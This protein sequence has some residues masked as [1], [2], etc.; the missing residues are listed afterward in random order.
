MGAWERFCLFLI[1]T[2]NYVFDRHASLF[3]PQSHQNLSNGV[4]LVRSVCVV[5]K[6]GC[7]R[8]IVFLTIITSQFIPTRLYH[9]PSSENL[10]RQRGVADLQGELSI[11]CC[12]FLAV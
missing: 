9:R 10:H 5:A 2:Q 7:K 4:G 8:R 1:V 6:L 12:N 3:V 11:V